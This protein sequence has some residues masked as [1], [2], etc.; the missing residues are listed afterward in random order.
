MSVRGYNGFELYT[1]PITPITPCMTFRRNV[2]ATVAPVGPVAASPPIMQVGDRS[3]AS[4]FVCD[5]YYQDASAG[6]LPWWHA[7]GAAPRAANGAWLN[8]LRSDNPNS[9]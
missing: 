4:D 8:A 9:F 5:T 2:V 3:A 6:G 1:T 7:L